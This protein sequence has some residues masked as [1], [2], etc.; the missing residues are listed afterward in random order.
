MTDRCNRNTLC[1]VL[2]LI[3]LAAGQGLVHHAE[4]HNPD[5]VEH[6]VVDRTHNLD[7]GGSTATVD[8]IW[9]PQNIAPPPHYQGVNCGVGCI[10]CDMVTESSSYQARY[11]ATDLVTTINCFDLI[12]ADLHQCLME[13]PSDEP[14]A[15]IVST[16]K[17]VRDDPT[18]C[19]NGSGLE[20]V[21]DCHYT[22]MGPEKCRACG[23]GNCGLAAFGN[24]SGVCP[25]CSGNGY[26][27]EDNCGCIC[28]GDATGSRCQFTRTNACN[29]HGSPTSSGTCVCDAG[30]TPPTNPGGGPCETIDG[31]IGGDCC[32][33][34]LPDHYGTYC[35]LCT[36]SVNCNSHGTCSTT[37]GGLCDCATGFADDTDVTDGFCDACDIDYYG[38]PNCT[39][40][41]AATT[42]SDHGTCSSAGGGACI[43]DT[44]FG[45]SSCNTCA[46]DY[47]GYPNCTFCDAATTCNG[48]GS[49]AGAGGGACSCAPGYV[50]AAC[51]S[52]DAGYTDVGGTCVDDDECVLGTDNCHVDADCTNTGG[53]FSCTCK[54][55]YVGDGVTLCNDINECAS[56]TH[57]CDSNATCTNTVGGFNCTCLAGYTGDGVTCTDNCDLGVTCDPPNE[58]QTTVT[59]EAG[60]C[61]YG[62]EPAGLVCSTGV[63]DGSGNCSNCVTSED[64]DDG[65]PC[66]S[67]ICDV[68]GAICTYPPN[69]LPCDDSDACTENDS[70]SD[71]TCA[72]TA[73]DCNDGDP[74]TA[75]TCD[76]GG[77]GCS[78][79]PVSFCDASC[80]S[81]P[82]SA[83]SCLAAA[84]AKLQIKDSSKGPDKDQIKWKWGK[85]QAF[86]Q[87]LLGDPTVDAEYSLCIYDT[88]QSA[89]RLAG[90]IALGPSA[91]LWRDKSPKGAK[92]KDKAGAQQGVIK[93][94]LKPGADTKTKAQLKARG[95]NT[96]TPATLDATTFFDVDPNMTVQLINSAGGCWTV[97]FVPGAVSKND[98]EQFKA[99]AK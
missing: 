81:E 27:D 35:T 17:E 14:L 64:C 71:G 59:C 16:Y 65:N 93:A 23:P 70:C 58:C 96:P 68:V 37:L 12:Q 95:G 1:A 25:N 60:T 10:D 99:V 63:C 67:D 92:Y 47:Y 4:A 33:D 28:D 8:T 57:N 31:D 54:S 15:Q 87:S 20:R 79:T 13:D 84:K 42:C 41:D 30:F 61:N 76:S 50:G 94:F 40:C 5:V 26:C 38:Y 75:D 74:C 45:G 89:V 7:D 44:G 78:S 51:D 46:P 98:D 21:V 53:S 86:D 3:A 11:I 69:T 52:C 29:D 49:C 34:C 66:T 62:V 77:S 39:F 22:I 80:P 55:G 72:G 82:L 32:K 91:V 18:I 85:G 2:A 9:Y 56:G 88:T 36:A 24:C 97:D 83:G 90:S 48:N 6:H 43:C 73:L 19:A